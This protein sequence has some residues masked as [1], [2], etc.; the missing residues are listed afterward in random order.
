[1]VVPTLPIDRPPTVD[2]RIQSLVE[3]LVQQ[4]WGLVWVQWAEMVKPVI[5]KCMDKIKAR[6]SLDPMG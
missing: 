4:A 6:S 1:M 5:R 2:Y 3:Q